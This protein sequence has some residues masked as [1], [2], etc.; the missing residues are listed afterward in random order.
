MASI[1]HPITYIH[2]L[3]LMQKHVSVL[4]LF[5]VKHLLTKSTIS[6]CM[7]CFY[8]FVSLQLILWMR[9]SLSFSRRC[10]SCL[11]SCFALSS[12]GP[13]QLR[14]NL[15]LSLWK[16]FIF[17]QGPYTP[18]SHCLQTNLLFFRA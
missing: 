18:L 9:D 14:S 13:A 10:T 8:H 15:S 5:L 1:V 16:F 12:A 3:C 6:I 17:P 2:V 7:I 11:I 4:S